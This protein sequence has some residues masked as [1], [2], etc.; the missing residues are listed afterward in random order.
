M[1]QNRR[2]GEQKS[3]W[4]KTNKENYHLKLC[5]SFICLVPVRGGFVPREWLAAKGL[6]TRGWKL[7]NCITN[8]HYSLLFSPNYSLFIIHF[9]F[10]R[11]IHYSF[12]SFLYQFSFPIFYTLVIKSLNFSILSTLSLAS[13]NVLFMWLK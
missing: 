13:T 11:D 4:D 6:F 7:N 9:K 8:I 1:V 12:F 10:F 3:H 5:M 2:A